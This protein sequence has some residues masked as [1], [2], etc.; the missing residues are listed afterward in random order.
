MPTVYVKEDTIHD[1]EAVKKAYKPTHP[2]L[3]EVVHA[4][5]SFNSELVAS[6][7]FKKGEAICTIEG[8][9]P[10]PKKYTSVQ[11][12][13]DLHIEL[14][15]DRKSRLCADPGVHMFSAFRTDQK[16]SAN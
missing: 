4:E 7:S 8:A 10:G 5:G 3:F 12:S 1:A 14:N 15:S 2:G 13:K 16:K 11:V 9:T 6:K